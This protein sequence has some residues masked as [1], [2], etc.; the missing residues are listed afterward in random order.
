MLASVI[1]SNGKRYH[2]SDLFCQYVVEITSSLAEK[3]LY[4]PLNLLLKLSYRYHY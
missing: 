3:Q 2:I 1:S 4:Q